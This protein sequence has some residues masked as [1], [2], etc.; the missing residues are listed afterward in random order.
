[1][2]VHPVTD[3]PQPQLPATVTGW[4][5]VEVT[6]T[7]VSRIVTVDLYGTLTEIVYSLGLGDNIVG[8]DRAAGFPQADDI[9]LV[10]AAGHDLSAEAVLDLNPTVVL[11]DTTVGPPEVHQQLRDAGIPVV[12]FDPD[13][14][15]EG[16]GPH[17]T[18]VAEALGVP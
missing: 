2:N 1:E 12:F 13:R 14:T 3:D 8:R 18:A 9:P 5:G 10:S 7:D 4:D 6:V 16:V 11:T 17:I 15:L